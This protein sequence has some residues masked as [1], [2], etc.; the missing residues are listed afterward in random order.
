MY[1]TYTHTHIPYEFRKKA[2]NFRRLEN[3]ATTSYGVNEMWNTQYVKLQIQFC[4]S[5]LESFDAQFV[6]KSVLRDTS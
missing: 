1:T 5:Q 2:M 6:V 3:K 4:L